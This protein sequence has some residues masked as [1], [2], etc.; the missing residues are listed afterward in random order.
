MCSNWNLNLVANDDD[1]DDDDD[2]DGDVIV[3]FSVRW[4]TGELV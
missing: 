2:D 1:D 4:K 3:L